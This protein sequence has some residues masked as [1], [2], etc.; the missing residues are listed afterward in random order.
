MFS[1]KK[2]QSQH[3]SMLLQVHK[4]QPEDQEVLDLLVHP[5]RRE[6][7][8]FL[9]QLGSLV[10]LDFLELLAH[11]VLKDS[12]DLKEPLV[13][14][15]GLDLSEDPDELELSDSQERLAGPVDPDLK[16]CPKYSYNWQVYKSK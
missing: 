13:Y 11:P 4:E 16:V 1:E 2:E 7:Q 10:D 5:A 3:L 15:E 14:Q 8:V 9:D 12:L 6:Q